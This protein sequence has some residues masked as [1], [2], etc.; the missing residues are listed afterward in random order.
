MLRFMAYGAHLP[1]RH[2]AGRLSLALLPVLTRVAP[3]RTCFQA[4]A[5]MTPHDV[6]AAMKAG[7]ARFWTGA[8]ERPDMPLVERSELL[9]GQS[10]KV[11]VIGCAD[12]RVPIGACR[13]VACWHQRKM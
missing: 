8:S 13:A 10:P 1:I 11:M 5:K 2:P 4:L 9:A 12:S 6:L 7:N 3:S